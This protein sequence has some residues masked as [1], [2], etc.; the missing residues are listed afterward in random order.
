MRLTLGRKNKKMQSNLQPGKDYIGVG[1]FALIRNPK[2]EVLLTKSIRSEKKS[3]EYENMWSMI[4]GTVN[5]GESLTDALKREIF[6][7]TG[8]NVQIGRFLG[9]NEYLK[10]GKHWVAFNYLAETSSNIFINFEPDKQSDLQW[11][12]LSQIP[13]ELSEYT[14]QSLQSL[15]QTV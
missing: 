15:Q 1:V 10:E 3:A 12:E 8:L 13:A 2:G 4:G 5:F 7:E 6:E 14:R 9:Y 11:F